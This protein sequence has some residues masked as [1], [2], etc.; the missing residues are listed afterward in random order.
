LNGANVRLHAEVR[1]FS[2]VF[3]IDLAQCSNCGSDRQ[4]SGAETDKA[5]ASPLPARA[6]SLLSPAKADSHPGK[7]ISQTTRGA[8]AR[9]GMLLRDVV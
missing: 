8:F 7:P 3:E 5:L 6:V 1:L 2:G 4:L 9:V